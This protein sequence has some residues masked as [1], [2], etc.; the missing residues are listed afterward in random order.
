MYFPENLASSIFGTFIE[1]AP[2]PAFLTCVVVITASFASE[3]FSCF[4][5]RLR[6]FWMN[7]ENAEWRSHVP[8][9]SASKSSSG[10]SFSIWFSYS[11]ILSRDCRSACT[12]SFSSSKSRIERVWAFGVFHR[13]AANCFWLQ[14]ISFI[15]TIHPITL[16]VPWSR[17]QIGSSWSSKFNT[18]I[19][20][21]DWADNVQE[22]RSEF[23]VRWFQK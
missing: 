17:Q 11:F 13:Q 7:D 18:S 8:S 6:P 4:S 1:P 9:T 3:S 5:V 14:S 16:S 2:L 20:F 21:L 10:T 15:M 12:C 23:L 22:F 19:H